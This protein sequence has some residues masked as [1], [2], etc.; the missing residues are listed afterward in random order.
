MAE[1]TII[2]PSQAGY[3]ASATKE[4]QS[5]MNQMAT[6]QFT[7]EV[8]FV[9]FY[10]RISSLILSGKTKCVVPHYPNKL[11]IVSKFVSKW[12]VFPFLAKNE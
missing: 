7:I 12:H 2:Y 10:L 4:N 11:P 3:G 8:A 9:F 1:M 5:Q 6:C